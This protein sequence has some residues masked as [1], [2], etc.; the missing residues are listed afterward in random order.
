MRT[1]IQT[2]KDGFRS[3]PSYQ[4]ESPFSAAVKAALKGYENII[5]LEIATCKVFVY[6]ASMETLETRTDFQEKK[7]ITRI[8]KVKSCGQCKIVK[9]N[10]KFI[11]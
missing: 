2:E 1:F 5:L 4:S 8:P 11:W 9:L 7:G 6:K 3:G 10:K